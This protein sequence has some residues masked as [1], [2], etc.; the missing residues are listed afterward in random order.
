[1]LLF[2]VVLLLSLE[3]PIV[4]QPARTVTVLAGFTRMPKS[5]YNNN[6]GGTKQNFYLAE[7]QSR[8]FQ[9]SSNSAPFKI[10]YVTQFPI[11]GQK[12]YE[13]NDLINK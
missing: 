7:I 6:T 3:T 4:I 9:H 11:L 12:R 1:M 8:F 10:V 13:K 2:C 5:Q